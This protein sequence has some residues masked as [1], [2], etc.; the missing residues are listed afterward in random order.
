MDVRYG[1]E[2][3]DGDSRDDDRV[4]AVYVQGARGSARDMKAWL[5]TV[6]G[7]PDTLD[8]ADI[9]APSPQRGQILVRTGAV[10]LNFPDTLII[11]DAYQL[12]PPRPFAPGGELAGTVIAQG[13]GVDGF[14]ACDRVVA[15]TLSGALMEQV[16]VDASR[17]AVVPGDL[18]FASASVFPFVYGTV[19]HALVERGGIAAGEN[20]LVLGAGGGIGQ[21]ACQVA[22]AL[23]A[24]VV[25]AASSPLKCDAAVRAGADIA[26]PYPADMDTESQKSFAADLKRVAGPGGFDIAV[27]P[28]GGPYAEPALRA[29]GW[30]GRYLVVGFTA[31]IPKLPLNLPL[32]KGCD[33]RGIFWGD[34]LRRDPGAF[35]RQI[36]AMLPLLRSG[37]LVLQPSSVLPFSQAREGLAMLEGRR[38]VGKIAIRLDG[39]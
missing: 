37:A 7:G 17:C 30:R 14:K 25:A 32:L 28:V 21:A 13:E 23:G 33:I 11:R 4:D 5:S 31:G 15:V 16:T 34:E 18:D 6:P 1:I 26:V 36:G 19:W 35:A 29:V 8:L 39:A 9:P 3:P 24:R 38:A 20:V 10:G 12:R 27:D 22:K 2:C